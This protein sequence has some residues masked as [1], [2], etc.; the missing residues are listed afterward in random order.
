MIKSGCIV[1]FFHFTISY[2]NY[3]QKKISYNNTKYHEEY[4]YTRKIYR[5]QNIDLKELI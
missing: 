1:K 2:N 5:K 3:Y 4:N